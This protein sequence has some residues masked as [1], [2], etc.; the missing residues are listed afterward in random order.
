MKVLF[1]NHAFLTSEENTC[2]S[3]QYCGYIHPA[4]EAHV[5]QYP[6]TQG[7]N[8]NVLAECS[9]LEHAISW[10]HNVITTAITY[11]QFHRKQSGATNVTRE[12]KF[13][14]TLLNHSVHLNCGAGTH[15]LYITALKTSHTAPCR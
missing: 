13:F 12:N 2:Y 10:K 5:H 8:T 14:V 6:T 9:I 7:N 3:A 1:A 4:A 11:V 15:Y